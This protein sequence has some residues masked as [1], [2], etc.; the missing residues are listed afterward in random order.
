M[1]KKKTKGTRRSVGLEFDTGS[2]R[3]VELVGN[4]AASKLANLGSITL[5]KEAVKEGLILQPKV[6]GSALKEL[7]SKAGLKERNVLLGVFNQGV[8]V[9]YITIPKVSPDKIRNA[10]NFQAEEQLPIS[11]SS[12]VLDYIVLGETEGTGEAPVQLEILLVAARRDM[13]DIFLEALSIANLEA[14][15]VDVSS[16]AMMHLLSQKLLGMT[17]ALVN[18]ANGLNSILILVNGKPYLSRLGMAKINDLAKGLG[19][20]LEDVFSNR[21]FANEESKDLL[22]NWINNLASE[23]RSSINYYQDQ[24][25]LSRVEGIL[26]SGRGALFEGISAQLESYLNIP[27][28]IFNPLKDHDP[29]KRRLLNTDHEALEYTISA[30]LAQRGLEG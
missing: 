16:I 15:D 13:L 5:P 7:W 23:V 18:I 2:L 29:S 11:L 6:V 4:A 27:V 19:C 12:V 8:L 14:L 21:M 20:P 22:E 24:T 3:A 30:G 26:L 1:V 9:R 10:I 25:Q 28:R 17:I